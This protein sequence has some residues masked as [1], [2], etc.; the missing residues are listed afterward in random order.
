MNRFKLRLTAL[1][2]LAGAT[3]LP[4]GA[5]GSASSASSEGSSAS[6]GSLSTS[7]ETSSDASSKGGE[8][9]QGDY[10]IIEVADAPARA[11]TVR[12]TLQALAVDGAEG[13]LYLYLP[14]QTAAGAQLAV[15]ER[16]NARERPYGLEFAHGEPLQAFFLVV[17]DEGARELRTR[18]V[19]L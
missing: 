18:P 14:Q 4:A 1:A 9:A 5:S 7:I 10:R 8:V 6:V 16:V 15:G 19:T 13:R 11:G 3:A 17:H 2:L 12:V